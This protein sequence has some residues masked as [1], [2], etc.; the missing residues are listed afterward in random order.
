[1]KKRLAEMKAIDERLRAYRD[2]A[3]RH[4][5]NKRYY[6]AIQEYETCLGIMASEGNTFAFAR[7][8]M[9]IDIGG[10]YQSLA[11]D[12]FL[13]ALQENLS[14]EARELVRGRMAKMRKMK[15]K[16]VEPVQGSDLLPEKP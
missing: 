10:L 9:L 11:E 12:S 13:S 16:S 5:K 8:S 7:A 3:S 15:I 4:I 2:A 14:P 6:Q 1:M